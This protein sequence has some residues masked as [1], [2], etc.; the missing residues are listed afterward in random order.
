MARVSLRRID[1]RE[2]EP[3]TITQAVRS[4]QAHRRGAVGHRQDPQ[5]PTGPPFRINSQL[6][7]L[8][9]PVAELRSRTRTLGEV[10]ITPR[11]I[12][13]NPP[14]TAKRQRRALDPS[15]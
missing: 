5:M 14:M 11:A 3:N 12:R 4:H 9:G 7:T 6:R 2:Q 1:D 13:R 8:I 15:P 10:D